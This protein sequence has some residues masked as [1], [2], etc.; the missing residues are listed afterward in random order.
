MKIIY[1]GIMLL[2]SITITAQIKI[3]GTVID[4]NYQPVPGVS[5]VAEGTENFAV[6]DFYGIFELGIKDEFP[7]TIIVSGPGFESSSIVVPD[8]ATPVIITLAELN[9]LDEIV[10]SASRTPER[11]FESPVSVENYGLREIKS[12][13]SADFYGGL[14]NL[15]GIDLNTN[16]IILKSINTRGFSTLTNKR[17]V[18]L[19]DG[20]DNTAPALNFI[21]GNLSGLTELD[22]NIVELLPGASS[23]LYGANAFN[24]I[25]FMTS[26]SPF[27]YPGISAYFRSGI[28]SQEAAGNNEFYDYG[29]RMAKAFSKKFAAKANFSYTRGKD[30]MAANRQDVSNPG[31][32]R[33]DPGFDGINIYGD[34]VAQGLDVVGRGLVNAGVLT[35]TQ[36][37]ALPET[38]V[39]RTG[40]DEA[41]LNDNKFENLKFDASL[42]YKPFENDFEII[43]NSRIGR[44]TTVSQDANRTS[45]RNFLLQQHK[46]EIKNDHFFARGYITANNAGDTYDIRFTGININRSWKDDP[47]WFAQYALNFLGAVNSAGEEQAH[48]L[49]RVAADRGRLI[50]GTSGFAQAFNQV[51]TNSDFSEG[52]KLQ[53][54]SEFR[55]ADVNYNLS[56]IT[57]DFADV[58]IGGSFREYKL[59]SSGTVF[60]D[61]DGP[62]KYSE[63][64]IYVQAQR[65]ILNERLKLTGSMRYDKSQLFEGNFS[66]RFSL[67]Y[68]LG[69]KKNHNIRAS[70]QTGFRNPTTQD[71][72]IGL[73]IGQAI[74]IGS[75]PDNLDRDVRTIPLNIGGTA[76]VTGR[77]AY[78]NSFSLNSVQQQNPVKSNIDIVTPEKIIAVELG[79][80]GKI[81]NLILDISGYY[82]QYKDFIS[83]ENIVV[84]LYGRVDEIAN[85]DPTALSAIQ[86]EDFVVYTASTNSDVDISAIGAV[87]GVTAKVFGNFDFGVNYTYT[88]QD[89]DRSEDPD[90]RSSFNTPKHKIKAS[91]GNIN[92]YKNLGFNTNFRWSDDYFWEADFADGDIPSYSV[93]DAQ[94]NYRIPFIKSVL[95]VGANNIG[96]D[97][98]FTAIGSG[99]IGSQYY[100]GL[101]INNL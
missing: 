5:V 37:N 60:T 65:K 94:I 64:G 101:S 95:K 8:K 69:D 82:N 99:F 16:S 6:T 100:I 32:D 63:Y 45:L 98:Y 87:L 81:S 91:F 62:I 14:E 74:L 83:N 97:D 73:D 75:A 28:T 88:E 57:S 23:A 42:H 50:P 59:N 72:Y 30:W 96:G 43:Y 92:V 44:G 51:T 35:A 2:T 19:V 89:F 84:P 90:F 49:A 54:K 10:I 25:L 66:P 26:K 12:T 22:V 71:L 29:I 53:E 79:Y 31:F 11:V 80:R 9:Q 67:G 15:K 3:T 46:L 34:E 47:T 1:L 24:G 18:Q 52:S 58:Q 40:Y 4:A 85:G 13:T 61:K 48:R 56:H 36:A 93:F 7:L 20:A 55:H 33:S 41:D 68:T 38:I 70:I 39:S 76:T 21:L 86:N 77:E 17:F 27:D 78:E